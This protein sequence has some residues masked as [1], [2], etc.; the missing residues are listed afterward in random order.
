ML[1]CF[2]LHTIALALLAC[3][4]VYASDRLGWRWDVEFSLIGVGATFPLVFAI[5]VKRERSRGA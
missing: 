2:N 3:A 1:Y 4:S 5:Q